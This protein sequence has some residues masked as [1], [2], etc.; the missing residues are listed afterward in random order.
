MLEFWLG[1]EILNFWGEII[2]YVAFCSGVEGEVKHCYLKIAVWQAK[3]FPSPQM[4]H[5]ENNER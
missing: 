3:G 2:I 4:T 5:I 1:L